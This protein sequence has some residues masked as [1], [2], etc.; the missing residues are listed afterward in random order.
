VGRRKEYRFYLA[1][2]DCSSATVEVG[3][4]K[5]MCVKEWVSVGGLD[6][7]LMCVLCDSTPSHI[8]GQFRG[9]SSGLQRAI[10]I[11]VVLTFIQS[12]VS[13]RTGRSF[14]TLYGYYE[15][16]WTHFGRQFE[17]VKPAQLAPRELR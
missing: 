8:Q 4:A 5:F 14:V 13:E 12:K 11:P 16:E 17:V 2:F 6:G 1:D 3:K 15:G 9:W 10:V 7:T